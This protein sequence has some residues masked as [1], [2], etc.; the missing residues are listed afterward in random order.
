MAA[1]CS[2]SSSSNACLPSAVSRTTWRRPSAAD[3]SLATNPGCGEL[4]QDAA[5]VAG[6]EV[7]V[8]AKVGHRQV[9]AVS[10]LEQHPGLRQTEGRS[11]QFGPQQAQHAGV[12]AVESTDVVNHVNHS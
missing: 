1:A 2:R 7:E 9:V 8:A 10:H 3:F 12:E 5:E 11:G 6:V 4:G